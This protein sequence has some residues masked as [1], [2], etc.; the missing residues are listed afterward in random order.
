LR[1]GGALAWFWW[2]RSYLVEGRRWLARALAGSTVRSAARMKALHGAGWLAHHQHDLASARDLLDE[3][4]AL[5]R[6]LSDRWAEAWVLHLLGRVAYFEDNAAQACA[7]GEQSLAVAEEVGDPWLIAWALHLLGLAAHIGADYPTARDYYAQSLAIRRELGYREGI[8]ILLHLM[9]LVAFRMGD[10]AQ[11]RQLWREGLLIMREL[12][13]RW[14]LSSVLAIFSALAA[15]QGQPARAVRLAGATAVLT[16]SYHGP[17][18]PLAEALLEEGLAQAK[19]ALDAAAYDAA[20][21]E[22][23]ALSTD[24][25]IAEVLAVEVNATMPRAEQPATQAHGN[26]AGL[27]ATEIEVLRLLAGGRTSREI[28]AELVV[29]VSTVDRHLTHIY[30]KL[31]VRNRAGA[32]AFA[33]Q[34][35]LV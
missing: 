11:A 23:R 5:A 7:F 14:Q 35:G 21:I 22:G 31:G 34:H 4:L 16:E 30:G 27:T 15:T 26:P 10:A 20:W 2:C 19:Q 1:L 9:G 28:A 24:E 17:P 8:G 12:G 13:M 29:A 18:I 3:S 32:T 6:K 33:L 25:S